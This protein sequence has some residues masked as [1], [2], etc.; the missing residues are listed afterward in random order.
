MSV[1]EIEHP[2]WYTQGI[3]TIDYIRSW[4]MDFC[5]G[6]VIKYITRAIHKGTRLQDLLKAREYLSYLIESAKVDEE[7]YLFK[8]GEPNDWTEV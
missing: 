7:G 5:S 6:N 3:E 4:N 1:K 2:P 8:K